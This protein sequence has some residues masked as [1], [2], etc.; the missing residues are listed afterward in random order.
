MKFLMILLHVKSFLFFDNPPFDIVSKPFLSCSEA[1][2]S[3]FENVLLE[4]SIGRIA[5][6]MICPY[7]PGIPLLVPGEMIDRSR[8]NWLLSQKTM[9]PDQIP[10]FVR[11][12]S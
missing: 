8:V 10:N 9:W 5:V 7:P 4:D 11:V 2:T 12:V 1:W 6:E 3:A